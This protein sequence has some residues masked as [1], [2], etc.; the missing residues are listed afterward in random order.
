MKGNTTLK[1]AIVIATLAVV[2]YIIYNNNRAAEITA[3]V[4]SPPKEYD[5]LHHVDSISQEI[6]NIQ[7]APHSARLKYD[8]LYEEIDVY[9]HIY[10]GDGTLYLDPAI[11]KE[12]FEHAFQAYWPIFRRSAEAL[13]SQSAWTGWDR[14]NLDREINVLKIRQGRL[15]S[16]DAEI[17]KYSSYLNGYVNFQNLLNNADTCTC[18]QTYERLARL[19]KYEDAPYSNLADFQKRRQNAKSI[20]KQ[21]WEAHLLSGWRRL[22]ADG[23]LILNFTTSITDEDKTFL[24]KKMEWEKGVSSYEST[25]QDSDTFKDMKEKCKDLWENI[26]KKKNGGTQSN[27]LIY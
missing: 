26:V 11:S 13:F 20:A 9:A 8:T 1:I 24:S 18:A 7:N 21:H 4:T 12:A 25:T 22:S 19:D 6:T 2:G 17:N 16:H 23:N 27:Y 14:R 10:R 15:S 5:F 3:S